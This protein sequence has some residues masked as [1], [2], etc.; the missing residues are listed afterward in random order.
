MEILI[1]A[2]VLGIIPAMIANS[3][4]R[5]FG[6]WWI[7]GSLLLIIAIPHALLISAEPEWIEQKQESQGLKKCPYCA[8]MVKQEALLC[9]YCGKEF[10][11]KKDIPVNSK[12]KCG[13][14]YKETDKKELREYMALMVC[15]EC[16]SKKCILESNTFRKCDMCGI[17]FIEKDLTLKKN[18]IN[19]CN[20]LVCPACYLK[21]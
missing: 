4:G 8:E 21:K 13:L 1:W 16:Y 7:Y 15:E 10:Q 3:K 14:C 17:K 19:H 12:L 9:R 20:L 18:L 5:S 11:G 6:A 2:C